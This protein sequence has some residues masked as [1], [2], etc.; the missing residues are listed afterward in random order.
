M[1]KISLLILFT[2]IIMDN[3][4]AQN[5]DFLFMV[6]Q[7]IKAPSGH[8]TQPWL[9]KINE[10]SIEI[11]PDFDK[12]LPVVDFDNRELFITL[13][14]AT[15]NLCIAARGK[16]YEPI[17]LTNDS[18]TITINLTKQ[19]W[20][21]PDPLLEQIAVRQTNR[22]LYNGKMIS[23]DTINIL[24]SINFESAVNMYFYKNGTPEF[25]SI[26][27]YVLRGNIIQMQ[28]RAFKGELLGWMRYN[29]RHQNRTNDGLSYAAFGAPNLPM[30]I[31]K[32]IMNKAINEKSQ[33][34]GDSKKIESSSHFVLFT[35]KNNTVE[36][37]I[38]LGRT[39]ERFL[40][41]STELGIIH[42][43]MN[44][45]CEVRDLSKEMAVTLDITDEAIAILLRVGYGEKMPYS[46]RKNVNEVIINK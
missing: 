37:W 30:F 12:S 6:E 29:K 18:G 5:L 35:T 40:L 17:I 4:H 46:S 28:D 15:E 3:I 7:A 36:E 33:N 34:K 25:N 32:P 10:S 13:G 19:D 20:V 8:N 43:Y 45:P 23:N 27:S 31:I 16:G 21:T 39:L 41:K 38:N 24:K 14:C 9:F 44:Q 42:A 11:I 22:S 1:K 2:F 26:G